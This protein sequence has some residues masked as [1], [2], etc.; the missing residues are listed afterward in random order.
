MVHSSLGQ[1]ISG[2]LQKQTET[3]PHQQVVSIQTEQHAYRHIFQLNELTPDHS[4]AGTLTA[5]AV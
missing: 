5:T 2:C 1:V 3:S 4:G